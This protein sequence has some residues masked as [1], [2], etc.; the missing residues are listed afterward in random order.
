[1]NTVK[2][3]S[4]RIV[5]L[6][7]T[8]EEMVLALEPNHTLKTFNYTQ[9]VNQM[10]EQIREKTNETFVQLTIEQ[11]D[12]LES[13]RETITYLSE[14]MTYVGYDQRFKRRAQDQVH[15]KSESNRSTED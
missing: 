9:N 15:F 10:M 12:Q 7:E 4:A 1:V 14:I 11:I 6:N 13:M 8:L 5:F 3:A 2:N